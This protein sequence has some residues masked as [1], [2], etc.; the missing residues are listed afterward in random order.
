MRIECANPGNER[1]GGPL[2]YLKELQCGWSVEVGWGYR[3]R[4]SKGGPK[5]SLAEASNREF[6]SKADFSRKTS[7]APQCYHD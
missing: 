7:V 3:G 5:V 1:E 2:S 4:E 6:H